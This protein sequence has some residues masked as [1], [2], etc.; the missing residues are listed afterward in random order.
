[1]LTIKLADNIFLCKLMIVSP[2]FQ[3]SHLHER[4]D[5]SAVKTHLAP[6]LAKG[7]IHKKAL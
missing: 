6:G 4:T 3:F 1:M 7:E 5:K 2:P